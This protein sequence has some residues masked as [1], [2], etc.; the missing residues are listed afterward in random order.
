MSHTVTER[1]RYIK[2]RHRKRWKE[3]NRGRKIEYGDKERRAYTNYGGQTCRQTDRKVK[4]KK[5]RRF[6]RSR[7]SKRE[8]QRQR[9]RR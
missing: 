5:E 4:L 6:S 1:E 2:G 3:T 7:Q 8:R 9:Q